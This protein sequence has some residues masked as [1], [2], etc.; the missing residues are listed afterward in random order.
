MI[1]IIKS[2][3]SAFFGVQNNKKFSQD[4]AFVQKHGVKYFLMVRFLLAI[5]L[6][7]ALATLVNFILNHIK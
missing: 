2:V 1:N 7:L 5:I 3:L 6:L 4:D